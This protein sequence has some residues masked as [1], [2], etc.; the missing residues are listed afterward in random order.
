MKIIVNETG[1]QQVQAIVDTYLNQMGLQGI[2]PTELV[3]SSLEIAPE[4]VADVPQDRIFIA[5]GPRGLE[6]LQVMADIHVRRVGVKGF[7]IGKAVLNIKPILELDEGSVQPPNQQKAPPVQPVSSAPV[8]QA[9]PEVK[10][11]SFDEMLDDYYATEEEEAAFYESKELTQE[12]VDRGYDEEEL[13]EDEEPYEEPY[14]EPPE[15]KLQPKKRPRRAL[16]KKQAPTPAPTQTL[17][18]GSP[19]KRRKNLANRV[20][21][22]KVARN[23]QSIGPISPIKTV[24]D[25]DLSP[26]QKLQKQISQKQIAKLNAMR[27]M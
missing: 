26:T 12:E 14:E 18:E 27:N 15:P 10:E 3:L 11:E 9:E 17:P 13:Y 8:P 22:A 24:R 21:Q 5:A 6:L 16:R 1:K 4:G 20:Q 7:N 23:Q 25:P 19:F 2:S